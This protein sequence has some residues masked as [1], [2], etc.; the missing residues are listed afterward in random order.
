[1]VGHGPDNLPG[2]SQEMREGR[3]QLSPEERQALRARLNNLS[4]EQRQ[5][6][7]EKRR[8]EMRE[9]CAKRAPARR[10]ITP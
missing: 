4:P 5:A 8:R 1:M 3:Q 2:R 9:R 7:R 10:K 6:W